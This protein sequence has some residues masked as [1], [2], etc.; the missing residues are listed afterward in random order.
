MSAN[1]MVLGIMAAVAAGGLLIGNW[2]EVKACAADLWQRTTELFGGIR[3]SITWAFDSA[4][5]G[6]AGFSTGSGTS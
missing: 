4:K 1:P 5:S 6:V 2:D 3:D